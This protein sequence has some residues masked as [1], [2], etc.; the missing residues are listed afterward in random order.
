MNDLG[1]GYERRP[2]HRGTRMGIWKN[3]VPI[4]DC[5][6]YCTE[7]VHCSLFYAI[8]EIS[9]E[10]LAREIEIE[11]KLRVERIEPAPEAPPLDA[12]RLKVMVKLGNHALAGNDAKPYLLFWK[13]P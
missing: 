3:G 13:V 9:L 8:T 11:M 10:E 4:D 6:A 7:D 1:D 2:V 12:E 5:N